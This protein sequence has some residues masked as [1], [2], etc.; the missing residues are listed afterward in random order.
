MADARQKA[1]I[2]RG[3]GD[4][5]AVA[6]FADAYGRDPEFYEFTRT[7]EAYRK[8]LGTDTT[9]ILSPDS[10]FFRLLKR[11]TPAEMPREPENDAVRDP[12]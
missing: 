1:E 5:E 6:I 3:T 7:L 8:T 12:R 4:A 2:T 9:V 11:I 10:D